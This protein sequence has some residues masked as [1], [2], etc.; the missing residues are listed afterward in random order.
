MDEP[1]DPRD[2]SPE[3]PL[4][5]EVPG[6]LPSHL[7]LDRLDAGELDAEEAARVRHVLATHPDAPALLATRAEARAHLHEALPREVFVAEMTRRLTEEAAARPTLAPPPAEGLLARLTRWWSAGGLLAPARLG[8]LVLAL[9]TAMVILPRLST[10]G[11]DVTLKGIKDGAALRVYRFDGA[12]V[13]EVRSP[14][15]AH[16]GDR[17]QFAV[18][19][20]GRAYGLVVNLDDE[21]TF[22]PYYPDHFGQSFPIEGEE[23]TMLLPDSIELDDF[24]GRERVFLVLSDTPLTVTEVARALKAWM[25]AIGDRRPLPLTALDLARWLDP[26]Q[27]R[28]D[29]RVVSFDIVKE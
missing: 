24:V 14:L 4:A 18:R 1:R 6:G 10:P 22:S 28:D 23:P 8:A 13:E 7:V 29:L 2:G 27:A 3:D 5:G 17:V 15:V 9:T 21:G 12:A 11:D 16:A 26:E 19:S 20:G 25:D